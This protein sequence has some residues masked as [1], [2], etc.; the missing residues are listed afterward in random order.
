MSCVVWRDTL[1]GERSQLRVLS[2]F[3]PYSEFRGSGMW[4]F[5]F[6]ILGMIIIVIVL[7]SL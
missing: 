4:F 5:D 7:R 3:H 2:V 6:N 1:L